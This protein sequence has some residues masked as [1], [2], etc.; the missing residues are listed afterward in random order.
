[1]DRVG[2]DD[3]SLWLIFLI[4]LIFLIKLAF[5]A[6]CVYTLGVDNCGVLGEVY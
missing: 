5:L 1:M 4:F 6:Y 3:L 2:E